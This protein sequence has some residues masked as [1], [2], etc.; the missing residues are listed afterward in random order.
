MGTFLNEEVGVM[1]G[2]ETDNFI[3][4]EQKFMCE[5]LNKTEF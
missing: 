1:K 3:Q 5:G 4:E 2:W